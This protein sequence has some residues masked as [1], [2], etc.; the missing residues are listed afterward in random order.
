MNTR[1]KKP[2]YEELL[3]ISKDQELEIIRLRKN[4]N[5]K[6]NVDFCFRESLD[7]IC[8]TRKDGV[9][10]ETN[11]A[12]IKTLDYSKEEIL[13]KSIFDFIHPDDIEKTKEK[14]EIVN[15]KNSII[16]FENRLI[17]KNGEIVYIQWTFN[18]VFSEELIYAI[19][20]DLTTIKNT[21]AELLDNKKLLENAQKISKIGSWEY[22]LNNHNM[23]WSNELYSIYELKKKNNQDL[24]QEYVNRFSKSD[25]ELFLNKIKES[26]ITKKAFEVKQ[27]SIISKD[28]SKW[29]HAIVHPILDKNGEVV[30]LRGTTQDIT[31]QKQFNE[32]LKLKKQAGV[33]QKLKKIE[34][35]SNRKFKSYIENSPDGV[36]VI[37][38][39][40]KYIEVNPS[41]IQMTGYSKKELLTKSFFD[42]L[43]SDSQQDLNKSF[44]FLKETGS[45]I[46]EFK[47]KI[48][49]GEIRWRSIS[50]VKLSDTRFIGFIKDITDVKNSTEKI[51][52]NEKRFRALVENNEGIIKIVDENIKIIFRSPSSTCVTGYTDE[53]IAHISHSDYYHPDSLEYIYQVY[54]EAMKNPGK[55]IPTLF[56]VK[57]KEGHYIWLEG[58][59]N[60]RFHDSSINGII[61]N[62]RDV[63]ARINSTEA[64]KKERD[65]F[66]KIA[67]TSPGLIYSMRQNL[68]GS[69]SYPYASDAIKDI[70]GFYHE[71]IKNN[72]EKF[73]ELIH[74]DDIDEVKRK[75]TNT[76]TNLVPLKGEY[77]YFHPT[78]GLVWHEVNSLPVVEPEGTVICHG[79]TTDVTE[80][81]EAKQKI[82]KANRL[83]LFISQINQ[84]I[85]RTVD[86]ETLFR[87]ACTIAVNLGQ[88]KMAWIGLVDANTKNVIPEMIKGN[89][90]EYFEKI[91]TIN[92]DKNTP[93]G[94]GPVGT[95]IRE[96]VYCVSNDIEN[97]SKMDPWKKDALKRDFKSMI[98]FPIKKFNNVIGA[99]AFYSDEKYFFDEEEIALLE[100]ATGD[101]SFALE[102]FEKEALK[103]KAEREV[104]ES[105]HRYHT[106][107]EVSPVGIFRTDATGYTT[108]VNPS[109]C[110]IS[111]MAFHKALGNGWFDAVHE[112][113]KI[114]L[115]EGWNNATN[116]GEKSITEYRFK[117]SDGSIAWV[118]G[119]AIPEKNNKNEIIGYIGTV[120]EITDRKELEANLIIAKNTAETANK[121]KSNFL[122]NMS[123]EIRTPLNGIIG[124]TNLLLKTKL[125]NNQLEYMS[126]INVSASLLLDIVNDVLDF[127]KIESGK[128]ELYIE[129]VDLY[130]L[131]QQI[132][133]LFKYQAS[134]KKLELILDIDENVPQYVEVDSIKLKQI[135]VNLMS[136]ALKFTQVGI[137]R[138]EIKKHKAINKDISSLQFSVKDTGKGIKQINHKKIFSSFEQ[139]D[140]STNRK[141]GGTGLGLTISNQLLA[142]MDSKLEINST[143]GK[144]SDFYFSINV[145]KIKNKKEVN[146][147]SFSDEVENSTIDNKSF[148]KIL[149]AEDNKINMLL[150]KTLVKKIA[151][152]SIILSAFDGAEAIALYIKEKPD[153]VLMD[154]QM[155]NK[156]GYEATKEIRLLHPDIKT[157]II[158]ITAGILTDEKEKCIEVGMDDYLPKPI[159]FSD[160]ESIILK[161][162]KHIH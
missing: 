135:L 153:L 73:F 15:Q 108:Y 98:S 18:R 52:N 12:F 146:E 17:K 142:L 88:F 127:S 102:L 80:R 81:I 89:D 65:I 130:K 119:Q 139:E 16:D 56:Q 30:A 74:P 55:L 85:V 162:I 144:G 78:K 63:T 8:K 11:P 62:F 67:V 101:V 38:D 126:T 48:K 6:I 68:D 33:A 47:S 134:D 105:E 91:K 125:D 84:M 70:F 138:L 120:T 136:N 118:M 28:K 49:S 54:E 157:P 145:K 42:L 161:W 41:A 128:L 27:C 97:D 115:F 64:L 26:K 93:E 29:V 111:G 66:N 61:A 131:L 156:N 9:F 116:I 36:I 103:E 3:K 137:V 43:I 94:N 25:V 71:E 151:P 95:S 46:G 77:R 50:A 69:Y 5:S 152:N 109:W 155:P 160:L 129:K 57:H 10:I 35:E 107:T 4:E 132:I 121:S 133:D 158:A 122:A 117:R 21:Q 141:F 14:L 99:F 23:I 24:F 114:K 13:A 19:G 112:D 22:D 143:Y 1:E 20:R 87:E 83:Y 39:K 34:E 140:N 2:T 86:Q 51:E 45:V 79:I 60:N 75:I 82:Q 154:I 32:I 96:G 59:I 123:H 100:E 58:V 124:F 40:G 149:I 106:L 53:E 147:T 104:F 113:D 31:E 72:V 92:S 44:K 90:Q 159:V 110:E 150:A 76:K 7:L 148:L 37:D